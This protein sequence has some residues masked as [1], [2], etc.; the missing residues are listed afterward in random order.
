M[1]EAEGEEGTLRTSDKRRMGVEHSQAG[2]DSDDADTD[3]HGN[4]DH[5]EVELQ[6]VSCFEQLPRLQSFQSTK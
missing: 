1:G 4:H 3:D 5:I 6:F 2:K